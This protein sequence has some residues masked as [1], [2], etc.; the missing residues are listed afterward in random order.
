MNTED[1]RAPGATRLPFDG[2]VEV[3]GALGPSF[4]AQAVNVSED[5]MH[6]RT[7]YLPEQGQPL[8][9]RFDA[10]PGQSVLVSGEVVWS[11]G[12]EKGGEFGVRF[13]DMD[14]ESVDSLK[15]VCGVTAATEAP[16]VQAGSKVRLH[17]DGL[18]SPMRAKIRDARATAVTVGSD[19]GF[20]Q[21]GRQLE[22][23]DAQSGKKRPASIDRVEVAVDPASQVPQLIVTL[24]YS[25]MHAPVPTEVA[26]AGR[27]WAPP[28][29]PASSA[30]DLA[31]VEEASAMMKGALARN[32]TRVGPAVER[33]AERA[34]TMVALLAKRREDRSP[35]RRTTA[36]APGGGLHATGRRVVRGDEGSPGD[37]GANDAAAP[38]TATTKRKATIAAAVMLAAVV[39]AIA[40]K[41][42]HHDGAEAAAPAA[43]GSTATDVA[44]PGSAAP[45]T[46]PPE[47]T[48]A[49]SQPPAA[50]PQPVAADDSDGARPH[51]KHLHVAPF[52]NGPVHHGNVLRLKMDEAIESIEGAQQ[53]TGF[54]V[55]IPGRKAVEAAAP[56][57]ARDSRIA[58]IK[59]ANEG[60]GAELSVTFKDGVPNYQVR[61]K[62]DTLEIVL[63]VAGRFIETNDHVIPKPVAN[64]TKR[65][66]H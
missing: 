7:A 14:A 60:A 23:E 28:P 2:L 6:L 19:L 33:L 34:K 38:R 58:A 13:T 31:A 45:V 1:R 10:G 21:V 25:D 49:L 24:R 44:P 56:L 27:G 48:G 46:A 4:E 39:G 11:E 61:A 3:G 18:A 41:K 26:P 32:L 64:K 47:P 53:P 63:A 22:L 36:P 42:S 35:V 59:V 52:G 55:K 20:L 9:C 30:D 51:K 12:A 50:A 66:K 17:I 57:A 62:G 37:P 65:L 16:A 54:T 8:T 5:G 43:S 29:S 15:R 40:I